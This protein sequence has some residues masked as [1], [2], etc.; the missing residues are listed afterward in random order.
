MIT[1]EGF[2]FDET[3]VLLD[4]L[5]ALGFRVSDI[6]VDSPSRVS[7]TSAVVMDDLFDESVVI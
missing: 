5:R 1:D 4:L 3:G 7:V 2:V 6:D